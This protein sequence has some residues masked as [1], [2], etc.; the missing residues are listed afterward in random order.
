MLV[1]FL[2]YNHLASRTLG[3]NVKIVG[4]L[5]E[6]PKFN[7]HIP[8]LNNTLVPSFITIIICYRL[9]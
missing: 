6:N 1:K 2:T 4:A 5:R 3:L 9:F 7:E 8:F